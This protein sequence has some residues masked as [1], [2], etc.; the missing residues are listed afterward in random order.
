MDLRRG[1]YRLKDF[2]DP[3]FW[4]RWILSEDQLPG[5]VFQ[6]LG[7]DPNLASGDRGILRHIL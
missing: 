7:A 5:S 3:Y 2:S 1:L 4:R 6:A